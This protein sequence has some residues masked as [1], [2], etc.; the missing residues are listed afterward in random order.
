MQGLRDSWKHVPARLCAYLW[1]RRIG[2]VAQVLILVLLAGIAMPPQASAIVPGLDTAAIVAALDAIVT[3]LQ[4]VVGAAL[5]A[6]NNILSG[7]QS[8]LNGLNDYFNQV[9]YPQAA[10]DRARALA[11]AIEAVFRSI[12][13]ILNLPVHSATLPNPRNLESIILSK[14]PGAISSVPAAYRQVYQSIPAATQAA[15]EVRDLIDMTDAQ[16]QAA[17]K[18]SIAIDQIA[19]QTMDAADQVSRELAVAAPG[20]AP[21]VEAAAVA[22]LVQAHA[23]T[24]AAMAE[25]MRV[26]SI[27]LANDGAQ[28]KMNA[29][30]ADEAR[31]TFSDVLRR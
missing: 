23:H 31:R 9:V 25:L 12:R 14:N 13:G 18:R 26:R 22:L 20:T 27:A 15:P 11:G 17:M 5:N 10:I 2:V 8:T 6:L 19:E 4:R 16:A 30:H 21:M 24:Q 1:S 29:A 3:A 7:V 28:L